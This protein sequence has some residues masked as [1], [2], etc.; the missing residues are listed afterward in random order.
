M[1]RP[2]LF[3]PIQ[4]GGLT[5]ANRIVVAPMCQYSAVDGVANEWHLAHLTSLSMSGAGLVVIEANDV[6][7]AGAFTKACLGL[8]SDESEKALARIVSVCHERGQAAIG[9]QLTHGGRKAACN[10][11]WEQGGR[12]LS[13]SEAWPTVAPSAISYGEGWSLPTVLDAAG[14]ARIRDAFAASARRA[15][16][17]GVASLELHAAHGYLLHQFLSPLSNQRTDAYGGS[18]EKRM[19]FPLEV[20]E[21]VRE[22]WPAERPLGLRISGHD[23]V[24]GGQTIDGAVAFAKELKRRGCDFVCVSSGGLVPAAAIKI[25]P[26]YQVPFAAKVREETG[27]PVRAVGLITDPHHANEIIASGQA[28]MVA[29]ARGFLDDPRWGWHAAAELG[30]KIPYPKQYERCHFSLWPGSKYFSASDAYYD[31]A[32]FMPRGLG[33]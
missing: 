18:S 9:L 3:E 10:A 2:P 4:L 12:P 15:A 29:L 7:P 28:D 31:S 26:G 6:E 30:V 32:R 19:R 22:A 20:T 8:Y 25:G 17:A 24:D 21:A 14:L 1:T 11:P 27:L 23:W 13:E 5:L 16:R 33:S